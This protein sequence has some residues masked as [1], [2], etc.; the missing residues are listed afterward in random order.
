MRKNRIGFLRNAG[1][2]FGLSSLVFLSA[3]GST[4]PSKEAIQKACDDSYRAMT[5]QLNSIA[6]AASAATSPALEQEF[7][8]VSDEWAALAKQDSQYVPLIAHFASPINKNQDNS[9]E[10]D[11][12]CPLFSK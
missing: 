7:K 5:D 4:G 12:A 2:L 6:S 1:V 8:S 11:R 9:G 10:F 3:C